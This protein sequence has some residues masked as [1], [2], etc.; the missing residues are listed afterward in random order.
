MKKKRH[1]FPKI[2]LHIEG[3]AIFIFCLFI[4]YIIQGNWL[5]FII[6][7]LA[8]DIFMFG[9]H[10]NKKVGSIIY[11]VFHIYIIP[12][13]II[14]TALVIKYILSMIFIGDL[15][16]QIGIIWSAHI[17]LDRMLGMGLKY[18]SHFKHTHF[19]KL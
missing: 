4:Y 11:N 8:P 2:L 7:L 16:L 3:A 19:H 6:L 9:Y 18:P 15:L 10:F 14:K 1:S 12:L 13:I 17:S 5:L